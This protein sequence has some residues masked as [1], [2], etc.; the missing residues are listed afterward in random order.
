MRP[1]FL[2]AILFIL[3]CESPRLGISE[4]QPDSTFTSASSS[5]L[6]RTLDL[7]AAAALKE[8]PEKGPCRNNLSY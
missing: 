7:R 5:P 3:P 4:L 2:R 1:Y 6:E 8:K